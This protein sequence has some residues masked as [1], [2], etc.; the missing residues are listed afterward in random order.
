MNRHVPAILR[1]Q[2][3]VGATKLDAAIAA[4]LKK[5]AYGG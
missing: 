3:Q 4:N 5:F 2:Q 1:E